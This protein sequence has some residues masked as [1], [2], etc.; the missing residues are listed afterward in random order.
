METS[1]SY[2]LDTYALIEIIKNNE[3]FKRFEDT[4]NFTSFMNLLEVHYIIQREFGMEKADVIISKLKEIAVY[5][6]IQDVKEASNFKFKYS[7]KNFS[8]IDCLG[9]AMALNRNIKFLTGDKEFEK[10]ENVE[11]V[12]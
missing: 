9:Y 8:Y 11:F 5:I 2:F 3:N 12:K 10:L 1:Q 7:K 6:D 4:I